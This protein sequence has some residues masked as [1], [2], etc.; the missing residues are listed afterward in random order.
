MLL[1]MRLKT[2]T[3]YGKESEGNKFMAEFIFRVSGEKFNIRKF[4]KTSGWKVICFRVKG[5]K[6]SFK[7]KGGKLLKTEE[8]S[9]TSGFNLEIYSS[10]QY[11]KKVCDNG[12]AK[13]IKFI[14][15]NNACLKL[16][17]KDKTIAMSL[18][19]GIIANKNF[20]VETCFKGEILKLA[21]RYNID[22]VTTVY[23]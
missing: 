4:L 12:V 23:P 17:E 1:I 10:K 14:K 20:S 6:I 9:D 3:K 16:L 15:D 8:I 13:A 19:I 18:D 7:G 21:Y 11:S 2:R 5:E 22:L